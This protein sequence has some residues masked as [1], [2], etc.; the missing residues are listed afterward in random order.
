MNPRLSVLL[1]VY[2][3]ARHLQSAIDSILNQEFRDFELLIVDDASSDRT[4]DI[5]ASQSDPRLRSWRHAENQGLVLTLNE[6]LREAR[7]PVVA[8]QD[9]DDWSHPA[10]LRRQMNVLEADP[11]VTAI[12]CDAWLVSASG[13]YCGRMRTPGCAPAVRWDLCFRNP[14][15]HSGAMF[16]REAALR[17]GGYKHLTACEDYE[18]WSRLAQCGKVQS[19]PAP[20]VK[21]RIHETSIMGRENASVSDD[22]LH[23]RREIA[24]GNIRFIAGESLAAEDEGVL[25]DAWHGKG[26][27][28]WRHYF[29]IRERLAGRVSS[30]INARDSLLADEDYT[31]FCRLWRLDKREAKAFLVELGKSNG[32][33]LI[34]LP[35]LRMAAMMSRS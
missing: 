31:L 22:H 1:P 12:F 2:N 35:W 16:N 26:F 3:G 7:A 20:L 5:L 24:L 34:R 23:A 14:F 8:R 25:L 17:D 32:S 27:P 29:R 21:Y 4:P 6:L 30:E 18:L 13:R 19:L 9:H 11:G 15:P 28:D 10:R 33:R